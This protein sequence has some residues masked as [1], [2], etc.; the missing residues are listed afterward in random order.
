M[1]T[2]LTRCA[3]LTE[4]LGRPVNGHPGT[5]ANYVM[6]EDR[7]GEISVQ[8]QA[9]DHESAVQVDIK[10]ADISA[11]VELLE[12]L[13]ATLDLELERWVVMRRTVSP[14]IL[15]RASARRGFGERPK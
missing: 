2:T 13:G 4:A 8:I 1:S 6:P 5:R 11:D 9:V 12:K 10:T 15:H 3:R 14:T 7:P